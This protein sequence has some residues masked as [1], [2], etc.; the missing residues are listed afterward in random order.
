MYKKTAFVFLL[1]ELVHLV[2]EKRQLSLVSVAKKIGIKA[3]II[4]HMENGR[5]IITDEEIQIFLEHYNYSLEVFNEM[6][7]I[8]PLTKNTTNHYF[9]SRN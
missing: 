3:E 7:K 8:K 1:S 9:L 4:D 5:R 6:L 2:I